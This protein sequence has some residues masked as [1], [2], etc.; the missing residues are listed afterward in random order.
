[1]AKFK[2]GESKAAY[3]VFAHMIKN[4]MKTYGSEA[5]EKTGRSRGS[6]GDALKSLFEYNLAEK[7]RKGNTVWYKTDTEKIKEYFNELWESESDYIPEISDELLQEYIEIYVRDNYSSTIKKMLVE[8]L[9]IALQL[10]HEQG[11]LPEDLDQEYMRLDEY[12]VGPSS[13][14][15]HLKLALEETET[16][17]DH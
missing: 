1:M 16:R 5:A 6:C 4:G 12:Y 15:K 14:S 13:P 7:N 17:E 9:F 8:D 2:P 3:Q 10:L 11:E